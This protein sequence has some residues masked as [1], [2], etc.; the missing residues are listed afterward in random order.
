MTLTH[1][2]IAHR[3]LTLTCLLLGAALCWPP[4]HA[5]MTAAD[6]KTIAEASGTETTT[7]ADG[8][9]RIGWSRTDVDVSVDGMHLHP[10]A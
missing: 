3:C 10:A 9:V 1:A 6:A 8:V 2:Q 7:T 5:A 4:A